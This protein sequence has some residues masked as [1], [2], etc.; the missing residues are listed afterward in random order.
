M[1]IELVESNRKGKRSLGGTLSSVAL[2]TILIS[3]AIA[4]TA[5]ARTEKPEA[6]VDPGIIFIPQ[7]HEAIPAPR[8]QP[9]QPL[10]HA[11]SA[12][13]EITSPPIVAPVA[14]ATGIPDISPVEAAPIAPTGSNTGVGEPNTGSESPSITGPYTNFQ[15]D[16]EVRA[17]ASNRPPTYPDALRSRGIEGEVYVRFVVDVSGHVDTKTIEM[18]TPSSPLFMNAVRYSLERARFQPAEAAGRKVAQLVEQ[19]FQF[20]LDPYE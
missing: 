12:P 13:W 1:F 6:E 5:N 9:A 14:V 15:V 17:F 2:H 7:R 4:A 19:R 10:K 20:R 3:L 18:L 16:R 8:T 11:A